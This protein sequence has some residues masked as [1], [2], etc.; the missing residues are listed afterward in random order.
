MSTR[1]QISRSW[2]RRAWQP[3][4]PAQRYQQR[5][6]RAQAWSAATG[7]PLPPVMRSYQAASPAVPLGERDRQNRYSRANGTETLTPAQRKRRTRKR[8]HQAAAR[9][10]HHAARAV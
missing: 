9:R 8:N 4:P 2:H 1:D 10:R 7:R 6:Q 3:L 5:W